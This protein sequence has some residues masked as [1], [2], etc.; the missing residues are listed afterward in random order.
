MI[1]VDTNILVRIVTGEGAEAPR[2]RALV[3]ENEVFVGAT[4]LLETSWVL[5]RIYGLT[6]AEVV[7]ALRGLLGLPR[8]AFERR[9]QMVQA[10]AWAEAGMEVADAMHLALTPEEHTFA[11]FDR[12]LLR[13]PRAVGREVTPP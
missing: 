2:A 13:R 1:A 8:A 9:R 3:A 7:E 4:V 12:A 10:L 6:K 5:W 11:T